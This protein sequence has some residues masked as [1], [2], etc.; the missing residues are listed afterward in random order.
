MLTL[1]LQRVGKKKSPSYRLIVSEKARDTQGKSLEILGT[2]NPLPIAKAIAFKAD[3]VKHWLSLG[4]QASNTVH[5]LL[6]SQGIIAGAGT[7]K[8]K[9]VAVS[10]KRHTAIDAKKKSEEAA[11]TAA[12]DAKRALEE[13]K[14][15]AEEAAQAAAEEAAL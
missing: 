7:E 13:S 1:R 5:N 12:E 10:V 4:A 6:V 11:K 15:A 3:R 8:R 9:S 2:Y 14:K